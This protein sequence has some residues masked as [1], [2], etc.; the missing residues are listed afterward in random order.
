MMSKSFAPLRRPG[1]GRLTPMPCIAP[2]WSGGQS[3]FSP[4]LLQGSCRRRGDATA[5]GGAHAPTPRLLSAGS[6]VT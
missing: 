1:E 3:S 6:S 5:R 2:S 4:G